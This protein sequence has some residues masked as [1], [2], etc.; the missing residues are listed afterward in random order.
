MTVKK[1]MFE[2]ALWYLADCSDMNIPA[3]TKL[4]RYGD[5]IGLLYGTGNSF[6]RIKLV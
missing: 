6:L 4:D 5:N 2:E 1:A 3:I